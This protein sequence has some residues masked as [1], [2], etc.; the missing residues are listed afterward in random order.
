MKISSK[1]FHLKHL[2]HLQ[3]LS[4]RVV[5]KRS[6]FFGRRNTKNF[7]LQIVKLSF[8]LK[9]LILFTIY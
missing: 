4:H 1:Y 3:T 9:G 8:S 6:R 7:N 2:K 5:L